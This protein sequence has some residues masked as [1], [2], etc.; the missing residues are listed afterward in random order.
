MFKQ[1]RKKNPFQIQILRYRTLL[2]KK[3]YTK[4]PSNNLHSPPL[5]TL[6]GL[7]NYRAVTVL[8]GRAWL[9]NIHG[10][11]HV[12]EA[13]GDRHS[14]P[15][16]LGGGGSL[17]RRQDCCSLSKSP[18]TEIHKRGNGEK[19]KILTPKKKKKITHFSFPTAC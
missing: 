14:A 4:N 18:Y 8:L 1:R 5:T 19:T 16:H 11:Q 10:W 12:A 7:L 13:G 9:M 17:G 3:H 15:E 6:F 2:M